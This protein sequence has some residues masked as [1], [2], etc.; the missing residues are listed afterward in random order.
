[1]KLN[2]IVG[3]GRCGSTL[4]QELLA[5]HED[6]G[7]VSN[8]DDNLAPLNLKGR[9]NGLLYGLTKGSWTR[10]GAARF[11]PSEAFRLISREVSPVYEN[12]YRDL[13]AGDVSPWIRRKFVSFFESRW[14]AQGRT[15][16][17]H[18]Y[19]GWP[20]IGFF[21]EIFPES[22]FIHIIR[23]GRA[24]ANS[25]L[26]TDWWGGYRGPNHW[27]WGQLPVEL[28][29]EW[30]SAEQSFAALAGIGWR[31]LMESFDRCAA[32][33]P[34]GKYYEVRYE[35]ILAQPERSLRSIAEMIDLPWS[36]RLSRAVSR[37]QFETSRE[38]AFK[39]DLTPVQVA[40]I[41]RAT[42]P[43]LRRHGYL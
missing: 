1:V 18:K 14:K 30:T 31:L 3:T 24:V 26:Q 5:N 34:A 13:V 28:Q 8:L 23:D 25:W 33:M 29:D 39:R 38:H 37:H 21:A 20:R 43:L 35:D 41:E 10:K 2:F 32:I 17:V 22:R 36:G 4:V 15:N 7:F 6:V 19:T 12:S 16:F 40:Q 42:A 27:Q 11:A 9:F